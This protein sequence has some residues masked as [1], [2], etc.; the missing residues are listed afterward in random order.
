MRLLKELEYRI[1]GNRDKAKLLY[2]MVNVFVNILLLGRSY[3]LMNIL[4][5]SELGQV[6]IFQTIILI[7][8][9][10]HFGILNGGYRLFCTE[11]SEQKEKI[12]NLFYTFILGLTIFSILPIAFFS[13]TNG[14]LELAIF[15]LTTGLLTMIK[16][17][18]NNQLIA[19][20]KLNFLNNVNL[21]T[22]LLSILILVFYKTNPLFF[23]L[24]SIFSQVFFFVLITL[25]LLK[26]FRPTNFGFDR[27]VFSK[28][29]KSGFLVFITGLLLLVNAQI[30]RFSIINFIG[31][32]AL[33]HYYLAIMFA[34]LFTLIPSSLDSVYLPQVLKMYAVRNYIL[35]TASLKSQFKSL[36]LYSTLSILIL[37]LFAKAG[38]LFFLPKYEQDLQY[39]YFILP[40]LIIY[41][42]SNPFALIFNILVKYNY[43]L[44]AYLGGSIIII[45]GTFIWYYF[46]GG[47]D[48]KVISIIKSLS[49]SFIGLCILYGYYKLTINELGLRFFF[50]QKK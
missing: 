38:I 24:L 26:E 48:L 16:S 36:F 39:V 5:Y 18:I 1:F 45:G 47:L 37:A 11:S 28:I 29:M 4:N 25:F 21:I 27:I 50:T 33:G 20:E 43:Y 9:S 44:I 3:I 31:L 14:Y 40:G 32:E 8:S 12:N 10:I 42:L 46:M 7:I 41:T 13:Y 22:T 2:V 34:T 17:W 49:Y 23:S 15:S 30:E 19:V 35:I 6:A